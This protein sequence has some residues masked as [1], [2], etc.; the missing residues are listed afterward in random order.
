MKI[1]QLL[2]RLQTMCMC[3]TYPSFT[4]KHNKRVKE[5]T[6]SKTTVSALLGFTAQAFFYNKCCLFFFFNLSMIGRVCH[7]RCILEII[8]AQLAESQW[9][10]EDLNTETFGGENILAPCVLH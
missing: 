8:F 10:K 4:N 1:C 5:K 6:G 3:L 7:K 2:C 9:D